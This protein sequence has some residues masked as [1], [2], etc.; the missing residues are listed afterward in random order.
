MGNHGM[1]NIRN[2]S[3]FTGV[4]NRNIGGEHDDGDVEDGGKIRLLLPS[5]LAGGEQSAYGASGRNFHGAVDVGGRVG[6]EGNDSD[7]ERRGQGDAD[8]V[9]DADSGGVDIGVFGRRGLLTKT[10]V[11]T[12]LFMAFI[13]SVSGEM[14]KKRERAAC[15]LDT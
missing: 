15:H 9:D 11:P 13:A 5:K 1:K 12:L 10:F 14:A 6:T 4:A 8:A 3:S 7:K 2:E